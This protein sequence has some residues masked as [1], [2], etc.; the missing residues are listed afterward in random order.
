M[1]KRLAARLRGIFATVHATSLPLFRS[2]LH[3]DQPVA[4]WLRRRLDSGALLV[5]GTVC[6]AC[7]MYRVTHHLDSYIL[8]TS[9]QK[10]PR[11]VGLYSSYLLP[12]QALSTFNLMSTEYRNQGTVSPCTEHHGSSVCQGFGWGFVKKVRWMFRLSFTELFTSLGISHTILRTTYK[13]D[14]WIMMWS[15]LCQAQSVNHTEGS[16]KFSSHS[17]ISAQMIIMGKRC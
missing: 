6:A 12:P 10:F 7:S 16:I 8:L 13:M 2:P 1:F 9:K 3:V 17:Q 4:P 15:S 14:S 5:G 11:L